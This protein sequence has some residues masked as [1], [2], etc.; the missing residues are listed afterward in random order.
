MAIGRITGPMLFSNLDRQGVDLAIDGNLVYTDVTN[1][2]VGINLSNPQYSFDSP[3][4]VRLANLTITGARI[5]SNTGKINLGYASNVSIAGGSQY[6]VIYT[7]GNGNL[8]FANLNYLSGLD[9]FTGN[10]IVL[11]TNTLGDLTNAISISTSTTVTDGIALL[12]RLL[13]NITNSTGT[14]IHVSGNISGSNISGNISSPTIDTINANVTAANLAIATLNANVG[15]YETWANAAIAS[16][17]SNITALGTYSNANAAVQA[18]SIQSLATGANAN[19]A[20]YLTVYTGNISA[21]NVTSTFYGN[22]NTQY[23]NP[24]GGNIV[25][26]TGTGAMLLPK[27]TAGQ[28]PVGVAGYVRFNSTSNVMEFFDGV[29]WVS[30]VNTVSDQTITPDGISSVYTLSISTTAI[31]ILV[32]INGT[33]QKPGTAYTVTGNQIT[34]AE[35]PQVTDIVDIRYIASTVTP[36]ISNYVGNVGI[37]GNLTLSGLLTEPLSTKASNAP[38]TTGQ[39]AWDANYIYV[40]TA[41]NTWKRTPLTGGY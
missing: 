37:T 38:G 9:G 36:D 26:V 32:S 17:N 39:I 34:F 7:D 31:A 12:N 1:R 11:G 29:A 18:I 28:Q 2:R 27:G 41:T 3:G 6:D 33:L 16:T 15:A 25:T 5:T 30:V 21:G 10:N 22:V 19:T 20:A 13:G 23:I 4:N 24:I 35:V 40:C 14:V 8:A